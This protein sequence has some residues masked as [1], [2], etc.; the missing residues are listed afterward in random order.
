LLGRIDGYHLQYALVIPSR[1]DPRFSPSSGTRRPLHL[2]A[3]GIMLMSALSDERIDLL[4]RRYNAEVESEAERADIAA[5]LREVAAARAQ[6]FYQSANLATPGTGVIC[7]LIPT[8]L[9]GQRLAV[10]IGGPLNRLKQRRRQLLEQL[11][12]VTKEL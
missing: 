5:T 12:R 7:K 10:G 3:V 4:L 6:G 9:R 2:T 8:P 11:D 1:R